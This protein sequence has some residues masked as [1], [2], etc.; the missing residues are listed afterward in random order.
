MI[1][2]VDIAI[3]LPG[4]YDLGRSM[5]PLSLL[6]DLF[7]CQVSTVGE[8]VKKIYRLKVWF[9]FFWNNAPSNSVLFSSYFIST[10][11]SNA[12]WRV[13]FCKNVGHVHTELF[14]Q[15]TNLFLVAHSFALGKLFASRNRWCPRTNIRACFRAKWRLLFIYTPIFKTARVAWTIFRIINTIVSIWSESMLGYL[16]LDIICSSK[17][18]VFLELRS[19]KIVCFSEQIMSADKYPS[20][21]SRQIET[22]VYV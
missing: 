4:F 12:S 7:P 22:I 15:Q 13:R 20:I 9:F 21:F 16:S 10:T 14:M 19:L 17:V 8:K 18:T 1:G 6:M 3:A 11:N 2:Q 5:T